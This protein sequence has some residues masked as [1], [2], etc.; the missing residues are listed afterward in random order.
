MPQLGMTWH[1]NSLSAAASNVFR[2]GSENGL[3]KARG[4]FEL[5]RR[6]P[7]KQE[8]AEVGIVRVVQFLKQWISVGIVFG[9]AE[10]LGASTSQVLFHI[11]PQHC[12]QTDDFKRLF[13]Q[14][15]ATVPMYHH[16]Y[17]M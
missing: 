8:V 3:E 17:R 12:H 10:R 7:A 16:W 9:I 11:Q 15:S 4:L 14:R 1:Q 6:K 5:L 13:L 2:D